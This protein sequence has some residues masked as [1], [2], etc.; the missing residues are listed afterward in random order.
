[1]LLLVGCDDGRPTRVPVSGTVTI[2]GEPLTY[3]NIR[4]VPEGNRPSAGAVDGQGRF[5]MTCFDGEDGVVVG[6]HRVAISAS[7]ISSRGVKWHAPKHYADF[8]TSEIAVE[9]T[10]PTDDLVIEL[11]WGGNKPGGRKRR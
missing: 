3:G 5:T 1:M 2:D 6:K 7:E 4:F 10:E 11:T 8:R 9:V